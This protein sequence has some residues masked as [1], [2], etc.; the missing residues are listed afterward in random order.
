MG[1]IISYPDYTLT[2]TLSGGV[3]T[4][5]SPLNNLK[6]PLLGAKARTQNL[7][8]ASCTILC[9][10]GADLRNIRCV[11]AL[12]H[13]F[14]P[15]AN[16]RVRG[17][18]NSSYTTLV[19]GADTGIVPIWSLYNIQDMTAMALGTMTDNLAYDLDGDGDVDISDVLLALKPAALLASTCSPNWIY[20]FPSAK[21]A[22]YW[23]TEITDPNN[24]AGYV[25]LGRLW[26]GEAFEPTVDIAYDN[27]LGYESRDLT[28]E[29]LGGVVWGEKRTARRVCSVSFP[30]I[31]REER[32]T[33]LR[34]QRVLGT[35]GE[36]LWIADSSATMEDMLHESFPATIRTADPLTNPYHNN[37][38]MPLE[39]QEII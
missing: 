13:N 33:A 16:I 18:S 34:M 6:N 10:L 29:S 24:S 27:A 12:G 14:S 37:Y 9:D 2:A 5:G 21:Q 11:A 7:L 28:E 39:L 31:S 15:D 36:L 1:A 8:A 17:Y 4:L 38:E 23:K 19:T 25:E 32:R 26:L 35:T 20:T 30:K 22:R 3:W